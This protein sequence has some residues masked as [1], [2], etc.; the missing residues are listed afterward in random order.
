MNAFDEGWWNERVSSVHVFCRFAFIQWFVYRWNGLNF[1][2][3]KQ[4]NGLIQLAKCDGTKRNNGNI[5]HEMGNILVTDHFTNFRCCRSV[6]DFY[7]IISFYSIPVSFSS[8]HIILVFV[9]KLIFHFLLLSN[10]S[11]LTLIQVYF[12]FRC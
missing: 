5:G 2:K 9:W 12:G 7:W 4:S 11:F 10:C 6:L 3:E 8:W 1:R